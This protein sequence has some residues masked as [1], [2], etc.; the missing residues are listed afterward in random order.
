VRRGVREIELTA[1]EYDLLLFLTRNAGR[2]VTRAELMT[3]VW[4]D[5]GHAYSNVI[6]V[7]ASR[8]RKKLDEDEES[9]M[10]STLRGV[11]YMIDAPGGPGRGIHGPGG[12]P[13]RE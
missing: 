1:K 2:V 7:Y 8:L 4:D 3:S 11:G 5:P 6:D 9:P 10:L 12:G 13:D